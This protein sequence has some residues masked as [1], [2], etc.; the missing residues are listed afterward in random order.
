MDCPIALNPCIHVV[1]YVRM[2]IPTVKVGGVD[3]EL[4]TLWSPSLLLKKLICLNEFLSCPTWE[5][6]EPRGER[7]LMT[8]MKHSTVTAI[9]KVETP[10]LKLVCVGS[11]FDEALAAL[12]ASLSLPQCPF[13]TDD[14]PLGKS[15]KKK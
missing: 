15:K 3:L 10:P 5:G 2:K 13:Q 12:E 4:P 11:S 8:F 1:E 7:S 6:G 9:L 14:S